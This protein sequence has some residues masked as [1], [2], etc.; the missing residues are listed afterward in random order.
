M[1]EQTQTEATDV[2]K[3]EA[4]EEKYADGATNS[5]RTKLQLLTYQQAMEN[6]RSFMTMGVQILSALAIINITVLGF[7]FSSR[8]ASTL[9]LGSLLMFVAL[10]LHRSVRKWVIPYLYTVIMAE[11]NVFSDDI[12]PTWNFAF[13]LFGDSSFPEK[14]SDVS[15]CKTPEE[16]Q[17]KLVKLA[18]PGWLPNHVG[19]YAFTWIGMIGQLLLIPLFM[20]F[21]WDFI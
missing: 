10:I 14:I 13:L 9:L 5:E 12:D 16:R 17:E 3:V 8:R 11:Q 20:S 15:N 19:T 18:V 2:K 7:A 6:V 4:N 21:G 1:P